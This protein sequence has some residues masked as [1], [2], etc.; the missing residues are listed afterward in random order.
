ML[1]K[2]EKCFTHIGYKINEL[3]SIIHNNQKVERNNP[4][5][6]QLMNE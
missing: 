1:R 5:V 4:S 6:Q 2:L 3:H